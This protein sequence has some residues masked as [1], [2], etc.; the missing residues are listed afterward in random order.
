MEALVRILVTGAAGFIGSGVAQAYLAEGHE[1][2]GV[3]NLITG[4]R[5][6]LPSQFPLCE[7]DLIEEQRVQELV[8]EFRPEVI[9][10]HAAQVNVRRSWEDPL[11]DAR[12]NIL[13]SLALIRSAIEL[14]T[15][16]VFIYSS[17]G[18]AIYGEPE[19][20]PVTEDHP[21]RGL[22]NYGVSKYVVELYLAAYHAN[23]GL[24][25][26]IF[27]YPNVYGPRQD[28][29][30]EAGVISVFATQL[31][32]GT[33]P[34]IFGNGSKTRDYVFVDDIV[35]ANVLALG[36]KGSG[37]FNLGWGREIT[38]LQVFETVRDAL[39]LR[40]EPLFD[41]KRPG[42]VEHICLD[43]ARARQTLAW[44]PRVRFAEGVARVTEYWRQT[45]RLSSSPSMAK[46]L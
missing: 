4:R 14:A 2:I 42:E 20:R 30:G 11:A 9:N 24:R 35:R 16:P 27:R 41:R 7:F 36:Y 44:Q 1:V 8:R 31:L 21:A 45:L 10:H 40:I 28:P 18:G 43:A 34:V 22:S 19:R 39:G 46:G 29:A 12:S 32:Q 38:D 17:S 5:E 33:R 37:V 6:N 25:H 13:G 15:A 3:D 26:I 23:S